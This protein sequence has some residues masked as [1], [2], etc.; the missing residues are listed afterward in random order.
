MKDLVVRSVKELE[1]V[2]KGRSHPVFTIEGELVNNLV[3]SG[4]IQ[5]TSEGNGCLEVV[6]PP[7]SNTKE[8]HTVISILRDLNRT[9]VFQVIE[10]DRGRKI[11]IYP[12]PNLRREG[13]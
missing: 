1:L 12:K 11:K 4:I 10:D 13:N 7:S 3:I 6:E 5:G 8:I 2:S 9:N